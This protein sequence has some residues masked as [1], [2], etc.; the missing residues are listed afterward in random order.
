MA[1]LPPLV[2]TLAAWVGQDIDP[3]DLRAEA[4]LSAATALVRGYAGQAWDDDSVPDDVASIALQVAA[5]VWHNPQGIV[6][7]T[8]DDY[9]RRWG[10]DGESSGLFLTDF[11]KTILGR[12]RTTTSGLWVQP[13]TQ[14][15]LET[16]LDELFVR[17]LA[18][19]DASGTY[20]PEP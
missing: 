9:S 5:R 10:G 2:D 20:L 11:E 7:E 16:P 3:A 18:Y 15:T 8:I 19:G 12:Y 14:G 1:T 13:T 6:S 17:D 4:V